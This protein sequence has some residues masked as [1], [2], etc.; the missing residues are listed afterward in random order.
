[1]K[2]AEGQ[3]KEQRKSSLRGAKADVSNPDEAVPVVDCFADG[4]Q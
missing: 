1:M 4:S 3:N 2:I